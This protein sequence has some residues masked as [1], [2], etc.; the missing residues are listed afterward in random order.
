MDNLKKWNYNINP[1]KRKIMSSAT[2]FDQVFYI[3]QNAD[4]AL[5]INNGVIEDAALAAADFI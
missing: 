1:C 4:V 3:D 2:K 5:A